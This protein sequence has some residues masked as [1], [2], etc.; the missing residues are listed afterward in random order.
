[1]NLQDI[2][3]ID[4]GLVTRVNYLQGDRDDII[5]VPILQNAVSSWRRVLFVRTISE[6]VRS[7]PEQR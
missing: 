4:I 3:R 1:M 2:L 7:L 6:D 5:G